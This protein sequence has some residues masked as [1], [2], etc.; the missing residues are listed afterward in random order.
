MGFPPLYGG[1]HGGATCSKSEKQPGGQ[2]QQ[3]EE[4]TA[5]KKQLN[6]TALAAPSYSYLCLQ[7]SIP[8]SIP[9][10]SIRG[11]GPFYPIPELSPSKCQ[12]M[13][14]PPSLLPL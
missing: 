1:R 11:K 13:S 10:Y 9:E 2:K 3:W 4:K 6:K 14:G 7:R 5:Q 12:F 8:W